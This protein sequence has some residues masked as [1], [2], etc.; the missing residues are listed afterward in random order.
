MRSLLRFLLCVALTVSSVFVVSLQSNAMELTVGEQRFREA[1]GRDCPVVRLWPDGQV[2]DE[3]KTIGE[4]T[5][6]TTYRDRDGLLL[7]SNVTDPSMTIVSPQSDKNTGAALVLC[8]GGGYGSLGCRPVV[9]TANW[10]NARGITVVLLKYRVPKRHNDHPMNHQP[11]QDAQR[12]IGI[13]RARAAEW[14]IDPHKIGIG[15]FSAGG[16]LA[17]SLP[18]NHEQRWYEPIDDFDRVSCR[19]DF[20]VLLY[21]AYLTD[22]ILSRTRDARLHYERI[23]KDATPPTLISITRPDKFTTGSIEYFLALMEV[24]V[25]AELHV[26][27]EGGHG[28]AIENLRVVERTRDH[29]CSSQVPRSAARRR[30]SEASS[31]LAGLATSHAYRSRKGRRVGH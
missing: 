27:P 17:A 4:E 12:A 1:I 13:L 5:F 2:P 31:R 8:P 6:T 28:G 22:P 15:G 29:G 23:S 10:M 30:F 18:I 11:L 16:H 14:N 24:D 25:S 7:I 21:P 20:A 26:Y 19:P 3:P 9:E